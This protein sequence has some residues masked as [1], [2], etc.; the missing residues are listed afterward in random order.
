ML[1]PR[2]FKRICS[3]VDVIRRSVF[4]RCVLLLAVGIGI[5]PTPLR[6]CPDRSRCPADDL[7]IPPQVC[8]NEGYPQGNN[9][10]IYRFII[11]RSSFSSPSLYLGR[12][13]R[14]ALGQPLLMTIE[15]LTSHLEWRRS[16]TS[17]GLDTCCGRQNI[18]RLGNHRT[19]AGNSIHFAYHDLHHRLW[20]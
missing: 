5:I 1:Q 17:V 12:W 18:G 20:H 8:A 9:Q 6:K 19:A 13:A 7:L 15:R 14:L 3:E 10:S 4:W 11:L 16:S 2:Y